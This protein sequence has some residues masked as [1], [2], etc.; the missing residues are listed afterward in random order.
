ML[1]TVSL[2]LIFVLPWIYTMKALW[3]SESIHEIQI[4]WKHYSSQAVKLFTL[5][6]QIGLSLPM[7]LSFIFFSF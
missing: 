1:L 7:L 3:N 6:Y 4:R 5:L 2:F